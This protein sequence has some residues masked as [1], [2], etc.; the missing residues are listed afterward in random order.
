MIV[1]DRTTKRLVRSSQL[2]KDMRR[3]AQELD[4]Q[5][6]LP[7]LAIR[8]YR[9]APVLVASAEQTASR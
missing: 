8:W 9:G 5:I 2:T 4:L 3:L 6:T 1:R 7:G